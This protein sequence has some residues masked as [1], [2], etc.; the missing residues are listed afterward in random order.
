MK[1]KKRIVFNTR[2]PQEVIVLLNEN[3]KINGTNIR[4]F[5]ESAIIEKLQRDNLK[6][7]GKGNG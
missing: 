5:V 4:H 3:K 2:L 7:G 1:N 6:P